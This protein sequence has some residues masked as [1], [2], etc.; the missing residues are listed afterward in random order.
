MSPYTTKSSPETGKKRPISTVASSLTLECEG[1][2]SKTIKHENEAEE[3]VVDDIGHIT[4]LSY[5]GRKFRTGGDMRFK[6]GTDMPKTIDIRAAIESCNILSKFALHYSSQ[7]TNESQID[8]AM[9]RFQDANDR[10]NLHVIQSMNARM[11]IEPQ[12][13]SRI[14]DAEKDKSPF[15]R[16]AVDGAG[17]S[18]SE[19]GDQEKQEQKE[20]NKGEEE[21]E[22]EEDGEDN[23]IQF[24]CGPPSQDMVHELARAATSIFQLAIRINAWVGMTPEEREMDEDVN[25]IRN[26]RSLL[27]DG[28]SMMQLSTLEPYDR[29]EKEWCTQQAMKSQSQGSSNSPVAGGEH[30]SSSF[31]QELQ[32]PKDTDMD[33]INNVV[34]DLNYSWSITPV[35][36]YRPDM[37]SLNNIVMHTTDTT[38]DRN[39][40]SSIKTTA[41][42]SYKDSEITPQKYR[43]RIKHIATVGRCFACHTSATPLW[44]RGPDGPRSLCNACGLHYAGLLKR[45]NQQRQK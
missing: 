29:Q 5:S 43:K 16:P 40:G 25:T 1:R 11:S 33:I 23:G 2:P 31:I 37:S 35:D 32:R 22:E 26:K 34:P 19:K 41:E 45:Q 42:T 12:N 8:P 20:Q 30:L 7:H 18:G 44:R 38:F 28:P 27:M 39:L 24:G 9:A 14:E 4:H 21:V 17:Q 13:S 10:A 3:C 15:R 36:S 6:F